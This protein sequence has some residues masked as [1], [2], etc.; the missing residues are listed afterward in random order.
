MDLSDIRNVL[1]IEK[2]GSITRTAKEL[3]IAQ[4][5]LSKSIK[6]LEKEFGIVIFERSVKGVQ[7]TLDGQRFINFAKKIQSPVNE[8]RDFYLS[9]AKKKATFRIS[10]PRASYISH[11]YMNFVK[12]LPKDIGIALSVMETNST[13]AVKNIVE[14]G[15]ELGIV[16]YDICH[17]DYYMAL[18]KLRK[19]ACMEIL[20][21]DYRIIFSGKSP[22]ARKERIHLSDLAGMTEIIHGD[23]RLP[24]GN[25]VDVSEEEEQEGNRIFVYERGSQFEL[26]NVLE[27]A[28]MWVSP[29][30]E[31][32]LEREGV[33]ERKVVDSKRRIKDVLLYNE[34]HK[35]DTFEEEF[36][37]H[38]KNTASQIKS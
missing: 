30:P 24:N 16:R 15:Y 3:K 32:T 18:F 28:Y 2:Y 1:A 35:F 22:L 27:N 37:G 7:V 9:E 19:L 33:V 4:P 31:E 21:S 6:D 23:T 38:L 20:E 36:I 25:Y 14:Q 34:G 13:E 8:M 11:A 10:F 5:N 12:S 29:M 17:E 26:M